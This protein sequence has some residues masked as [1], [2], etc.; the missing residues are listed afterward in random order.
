MANGFRLREKRMAQMKK[1]INKL[2]QFEVTHPKLKIFISAIY[3]VIIYGL[4]I[5][6]ILFIIGL[7]CSVFFYDDICC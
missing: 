6:V 3:W 5:A 2:Q 7:L 4:R 1:I